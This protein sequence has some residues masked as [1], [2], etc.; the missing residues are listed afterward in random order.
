MPCPLVSTVDID[1]TLRFTLTGPPLRST[2]LSLLPERCGRRWHDSR[3]AEEVE[4]AGGRRRRPA[5]I[6]A[7]KKDVAPPASVPACPCP[8]P[9]CIFSSSCSA[10]GRTMPGSRLCPHPG[11]LP[12]P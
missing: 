10:R 9:P 2:L 1:I 8:P 12:S 3:R 11:L 5:G 6:H 4:R 7:K